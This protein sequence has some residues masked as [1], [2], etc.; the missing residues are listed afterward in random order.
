MAITQNL[1]PKEVEYLKYLKTKWLDGQ[2]SFKRLDN[3]RT[4]WLFWTTPATPVIEQPT[5][6]QPP[7]AEKQTKLQALGDSMKKSIK[8]LWDVFTKAIPDI[9]RDIGAWAKQLWVDIAKAEQ[10]PLTNIADEDLWVTWKIAKRF[11]VAQEWIKEAKTSE[12]MWKQWKTTSLLQWM[13]LLAWATSDSLWDVFLSWLS[14]ITPNETEQVVKEWVEKLMNS[15]WLEWARWEIQQ[16][17]EWYEFLK[18][19]DPEKA[20]NYKAFYWAL[21]AAADL[22]WVAWVSKTLWKETW[23]EAIEKVLTQSI[24]V[25]DFTKPVISQADNIIPWAT[26][27][28]SILNSLRNVSKWVED[29]ITQWSVEFKGVV[30]E[31]PIISAVTKSPVT[32]VSKEA[33]SK[34]SSLNKAFTPLQRVRNWR[35]VRPQEKIDDQWSK[36]IEDFDKK[37][38]KPTDMKEF[39]ESMIQWQKDIYSIINPALKESEEIIDINPVLQNL[40]WN[41]SEFA[42]EMS[43]SQVK[44][45]DDLINNIQTNPKYSSMDM[46]KLEELKQFVNAITDFNSKWTEK[47]FNN[48]LRDFTSGIW[49]LQDNILWKIEGKTSIK[50]LK[51][52]YWAYSDML[53]DVNKAIIK[54]DRK[55]PVWL[56]SWL[57]R[58]AWFGNIAAWALKWD[59][60]EVVKWWAQI[61]TW[62]V[63]RNINDANN[64]IRR[65]FKWSWKSFSGVPKIQKPVVIKKP[66]L[67]LPWEWQS[68][69]KKP[70]IITPYSVSEKAKQD[71][72]L[73]KKDLWNTKIWSN[74]TKWEQAEIYDFVKVAIKETDDIKWLEE[75]KKD[76]VTEW[77]AK[78]KELLAEIDLKIL[79]INEISQIENV[80]TTLRRE[81]GEDLIDSFK[82]IYKNEIALKTTKWGDKYSKIEFNTTAWFKDFSKQ[83]EE[84]IWQTPWNESKTVQDIYEDL[85]SA[86]FDK[87]VK[88]LNKSTILKEVKKPTIIKPKV[89]KV[90]WWIIKKPAIVWNKESKI[91]SPDKK[92]P[93]IIK[94]PEQIQIKVEPVKSDDLVSEAKK[95]KSVYEFVQAQ[96]ETLYRWWVSEWASFSTQ[97][98]IAEDFAKNRWWNVNKYIIDKKANIAEY[99]DFPQKEYKNTDNFE[100][101]LDKKSDKL[102]FMENDLEV[103]FKKATNWAKNNWYD[104]IRL[105]VEDEVRIINKNIIKTEAQLKQIYEQANKPKLIKTPEVI[106][107][108]VEP[109]R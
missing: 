35:V 32:E 41:I 70:T 76:I 49:D 50:D 25:K 90:D 106:W 82:K 72:F 47:V 17:L 99:S 105:P 46:E 107:K 68:S 95:Y 96:W 56:F 27:K 62:E 13:W 65:T 18:Q 98:Q 30:W 21:M 58:I 44:Q 11:Q 5:I 83:A 85:K 3:A 78:E 102:S 64:I 28:D 43:P 75:L 6:E 12:V 73:W 53:W 92:E 79:W 19:N 67:A 23:K 89:E 20:R 14:T 4:Q 100:M 51:R 74:A 61:L 29:R 54:Y 66:V 34:I 26:T 40:K 103:E 9:A 16:A 1:Q 33:K 87:N 77:L 109:I 97:K 38:V 91:V 60:K 37:G 55:A 88:E 108:K 86:I 52:T 59:M 101:W 71:L 7:Q 45:I 104:G 2:E 15:K 8:P 57:W 93:T 31:E 94:K 22:T 39:R 36:I 42:S 63:I 24:P 84:Y 48:F 69:F 80:W 10:W 81:Y